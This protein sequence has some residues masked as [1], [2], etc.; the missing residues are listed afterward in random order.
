M[1]IIK[2]Q[3]LRILVGP[4]DS[5]LKCLAAAQS[6]KL[7]IAAQTGESS[8]KD[9]E[10]DWM[11]QEIT[12]INWDVEAESLI[13]LTADS[14]AVLVTGLTVGETYTIRFSQTSDTPGGSNRTPLNNHLRLT[15]EAVLS[16][17]T[18]TAANKEQS[19]Y[20][21][22]FTGTGELAQY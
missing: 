21:A 18:L 9:S 6:C 12:A 22:K 15:G 10:S 13:T 20:Q 4:D 16:D 11:E 5:H 19:T 7:H 2:G 1:A 14:G 8:S 17:L 3:N